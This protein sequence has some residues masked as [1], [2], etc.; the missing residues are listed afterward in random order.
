M[1]GFGSDSGQYGL[2]TGEDAA[3]EALI[4][5]GRGDGETALRKVR[6]LN[7]M[8]AVATILG[9][10]SRARGGQAALDWMRSADIQPQTLTAI[11]VITLG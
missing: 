1:T 10:V 6:D 9:I 4:T 8:E 11:A 3:V 5:E 7:D 2:G